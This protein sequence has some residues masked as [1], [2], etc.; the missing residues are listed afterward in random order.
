MSCDEFVRALS[1]AGQPPAAVVEHARGCDRCRRL[2]TADGDLRGTPRTL[3]APVLSPELERAL[4]GHREL[5][6]SWSAWRRA[7]LVIAASAAGVVVAATWVP[8][9]D[10]HA[11]PS[12]LHVFAVLG[13][14]VVAGS[15]L[16]L[17]RNRQGFG[18]P[19]W[20]RWGFVS[21][22][23]VGF[24]LFAP[25]Y[26]RGLLATV[27]PGSVPPAPAHDCALL[28]TLVV[29]AVGGVAFAVGRG[30]VLV[31]PRSAGALAGC[32]AGLAAA[33]FLHVHCS[34]TRPLHLQIVHVFPMLLAVLVGVLAGRRLLRA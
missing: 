14:A 32:V 2:L 17:H 10:L 5:S 34:G 7:L 29:L 33:L 28:G 26:A 4:A 13:L 20:A 11:S 9:N 12:F 18:V 21:L 27:A 1:V 31:S 3:L 30:T 6:T 8:R 19:P 24:E 16:Y 15:Q 25:G 23:F 22:A